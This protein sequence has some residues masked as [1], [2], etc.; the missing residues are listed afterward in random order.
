MSKPRKVEEPA[1]T[2]SASPKGSTKASSDV[3]YA[4]REDVLKANE[5]LMKVH[6]KVLEKLAK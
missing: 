6:R 2:Y 3:R 1:G 5:Q 4:R